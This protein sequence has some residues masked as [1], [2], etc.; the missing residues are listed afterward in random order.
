V[1]VA[2]EPEATLDEEG[3]KQKYQ[4]GFDETGPLHGRL[5]SSLFYPQDPQHEGDEDQKILGQ[6]FDLFLFPD[7][8]PDQEDDKIGRDKIV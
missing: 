5:S 1:T 6:L 7:E 2:V 4:D 3:K 8:I